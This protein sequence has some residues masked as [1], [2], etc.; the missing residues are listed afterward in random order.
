VTT[1]GTAAS[2]IAALEGNTALAAKLTTDTAAAA[3]AVKNWKQGTPAQN[4][5]QALNLVIDDLDLIC[6]AGGPC[7]PYAA[8]IALAL[9]T[10]ESI[11]ALLNPTAQTYGTRAQVRKVNLPYYPS[12][13]KDFKTQWNGICST[14]PALASAAIR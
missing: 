8:L 1:L 2:S 14:D 3:A 6:P 4:A 7:G 9:G 11:I 12:T 5:I 10:A 13:A